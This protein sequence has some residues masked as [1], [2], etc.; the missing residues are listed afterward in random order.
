MP[1]EPVSKFAMESRT[2]VEKPACNVELVE[3]D[4]EQHVLHFYAPRTP[5]ENVLDRSI[6]FKLDFIILPL[7]A[8]NFMVRT[9]SLANI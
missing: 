1:A 8:L 9:S 5:E 7:L 3:N 2:S 4:F 6:N